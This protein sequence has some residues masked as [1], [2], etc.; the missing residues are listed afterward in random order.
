MERVLAQA[1]AQQLLSHKARGIGHTAMHWAAVQED[2]SL[3]GW[4]LSLG[5]E[6]NALNN[7]DATPLHAAASNGQAMSVSFLLGRGADASLKN[8]DGERSAAGQAEP[9]RHRARDPGAPRRS[10]RSGKS[11]ALRLCVFAWR[12]PAS[13]SEGRR[14]VP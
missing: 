10:P 4:L 1:D 7:S 14:C 11:V 6:V 5:A 8:D 3:M 2:R 12:G 9:S 13:G